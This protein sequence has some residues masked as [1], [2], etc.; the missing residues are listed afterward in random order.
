MKRS[1]SSRNTMFQQTA[2][3]GQKEE[4]K[5]NGGKKWEKKKK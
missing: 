2:W 3:L 5:K 4:E 1:L